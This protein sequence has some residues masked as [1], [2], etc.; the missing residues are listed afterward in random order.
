MSPAL[1]SAIRWLAA[2]VVPARK[3]SERSPPHCGRSERKMTGW[4]PQSRRAG[5]GLEPA[6]QLSPNVRQSVRLGAGLKT[7]NVV[8]L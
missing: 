5:V 1:A 7:A 4:S 3:L 6:G 8:I 2:N